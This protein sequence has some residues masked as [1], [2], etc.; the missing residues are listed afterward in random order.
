MR[1]LVL[2]AMLAG[3]AQEPPP[4]PPAPPAAET[5][6]AEPAPPA[7]PAAAATEEA[8][9]AVLVPSPFQVQQALKEA[10]IS[11]KVEDLVKKDPIPLRAESKDELAVRV[12]VELADLVLTTKSAPKAETISRLK[13]IEE[14]FALLG[15]GTDIGKK[16]DDI[17]ARLQ[18]DAI[19]SD[20]LVGELDELSRVLVPEVSYEAGDRVVPLI[21][22][23]GWLAGSHYVAGAIVAAKKPEVADKFLKQP[24]VVDYF[25][26]YIRTEGADK[27][28][29]MVISKLETS[30]VTLQGVAKKDKLTLEDV[31]AVY[32]TTGD[33]LALL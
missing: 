7:A 5:K 21:Q 33:V 2:V 30:L 4:P 3:C 10:G 18:N 14:G 31:Q 16:I 13:K 28:A 24:E 27:A 9:A 6:P 17:V 25:L 15:A 20:D 19:N 22:A 12:G 23:G 1:S 32:S 26:K 8:N 11:A 29:P